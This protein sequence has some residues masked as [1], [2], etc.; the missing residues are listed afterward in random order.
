MIAIKNN[1]PFI[2]VF[3]ACIMLFASEALGLSVVI[4]ITPESL[5]LESE[6]QW[7]TCTVWLPEPYDATDVIIST[8]SL[9]GISPDSAGSGGGTLTCKFDRSVVEAMLAPFSPGQVELTLTG[10]LFDGT[11]FVGTDTITVFSGELPQY[12]ITSISGMNGTIFPA[13]VTTVNYG[14]YLTFTASPS[15]G[16]QV[17]TWYLDGDVVGTTDTT[18]TLNNIQADHTVEVTF[19]LLEYTLNATSGDNG[20]INPSGSITV[21]YGSK[22]EFTASPGIGYQVDTW[23]LDGDVVGTTDTTYTLNDIQS[24]HEVLIL[25]APLLLL[26]AATRNLQLIRLPVIRWIHGPLMVNRFRQVVIPI[27]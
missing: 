15:T 20:T 7:I 14:D 23:Y 13:G 1:S 3:C 10:Q 19:R 27:P 24:D 18:Y 5:N 11:E 2:T 26:T 12:T 16:Y 22:Q 25:P 9:D 6:G 17:D 21:T 4:D 8:L